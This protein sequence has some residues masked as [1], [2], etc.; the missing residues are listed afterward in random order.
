M[1]EP[2]RRYVWNRKDHMKIYWSL[3]LNALKTWS[4]KFLCVRLDWELKSYINLNMFGLIRKYLGI[5]IFLKS[6]YLEHSNKKWY[7]SSSIWHVACKYCV[8]F[9]L[10]V[11]IYLRT[12]CW[13]FSF[14]WGMNEKTDVQLLLPAIRKCARR[15]FHSYLKETKKINYQFL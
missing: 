6:V 3:T 1:M 8:W 9:C 4:D 15:F 5:S 10:F 14:P 13:F 2:W 12:D 7:S 11:Y